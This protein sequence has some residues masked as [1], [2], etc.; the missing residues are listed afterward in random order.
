[1]LRPLLTAFAKSLLGYDTVPVA[2]IVQPH[3]ATTGGVL[4]DQGP[5]A[6]PPMTMHG[7][8]TEIITAPPVGFSQPDPVFVYG[9]PPQGFVP[10][11]AP[12]VAETDAQSGVNC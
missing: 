3:L 8:T 7:F 1:M 5:L 11:S 9:T 4:Y 6:I 2:P 12:S 10:G